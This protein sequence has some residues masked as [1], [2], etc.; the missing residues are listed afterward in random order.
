MFD[1]IPYK[2]RRKEEERKMKVQTRQDIFE[3]TSF[4]DKWVSLSDLQEQLQ[5]LKGILDGQ[6][7]CKGNKFKMCLHCYFKELLDE[8]LGENK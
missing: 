1:G 6:C 4:T 3:D 5:K 7:S 8:H 2:T